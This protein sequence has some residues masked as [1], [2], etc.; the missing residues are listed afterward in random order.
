MAT[1]YKGL[2]NA[3]DYVK[4]KVKTGEYF[5]DPEQTELLELLDKY[6]LELQEEEKAQG[7]E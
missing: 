4:D 3:I 5:D 2:F 6:K 1:D 7:G